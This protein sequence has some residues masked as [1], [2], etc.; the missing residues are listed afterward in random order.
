[1]LL[2]LWLVVGFVVSW[3]GLLLVLWLGVGLGLAA[4]MGSSWSV[5]QLFVFVLC[6][7]CVLFYLLVMVEVGVLVLACVFA[8]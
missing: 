2:V 7:C 4:V 5:G 3:L 6:K 8:V 1:L